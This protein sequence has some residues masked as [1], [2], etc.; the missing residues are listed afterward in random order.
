ML[1]VACCCA[2]LA[3]CQGVPALDDHYV[4]RP[5]NDAAVPTSR[6]MPAGTVPQSSQPKPKI[7]V[8]DEIEADSE[9]IKQLILRNIPPGTPLERAQAMLEE[10][11]FSCRRYSFWTDA[12]NH[13]IPPGY[14]LPAEVAKRLHAERDCRPLYCHATLPELQ[15]WHLSSQRVLIVLVPDQTQNVKDVEVGRGHELLHPD[16]KFFQSRTDLHE[17]L[18]QAVDQARAHMAAFGF[19]CTAVKPKGA[20]GD[21]RPHVLCQ[22]FDEN[23]MGGRIVRAHLYPDE[24]GIIREAKVLDETGYFDAERCMLPHGDESTG[25]AVLKGVLFPVREGGRYAVVTIGIAAVVLALSTMP[26]GH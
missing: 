19:D 12:C 25:K 7:R 2:V 5:Q 14:D 22:A 21:A 24:S 18:G 15:E 1:P 9:A 16:I 8:F 26:Y 17:P 11:G 4:S 23:W 13:C 20:D 3:G 6:A 10:Q